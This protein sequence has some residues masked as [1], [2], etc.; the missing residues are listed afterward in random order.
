MNHVNDIATIARMSEVADTL[1][2]DSR[3]ILMLLI[4]AGEK[5]VEMLADLSGIPVAST[6]QHL[7]V[8]KKSGMVAARR[9]GKRMLYRL[10]N[11]PLAELIDALER[12]AV[13][14]GLKAENDA[15]SAE[16][17]T[18][19]ELRKKLKTGKTLLID[20]RSRGEY[21]KG[22]ITGALSIP[23][24]ELEKQAGKLPP[25]RELVVYCRGPY[26][27]LSVHA[28]E[29]LAAKGVTAQ[30]LVSGFS[31]WQGERTSGSGR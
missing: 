2:N 13:F 22:H 10:P 12:F 1:G 24:N 20:V 27:L 19:K 25:A 8:L 17:I 11:G 29:L 7:Q 21:D 30:R 23:V 5:P 6:S 15:R 14:R 28:V 26:C 31:E 9:D 16:G 3:L 4:A 18:E